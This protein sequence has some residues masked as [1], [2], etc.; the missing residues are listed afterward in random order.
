M[1]TS[2]A[3]LDTEKIMN[4]SNPQDLIGQQGSL[5]PTFLV[6]GFLGSGKTTFL[7]WLLS[8]SDASRVAVIVNEFGE[9]GLDH[10]L[11]ATPVENIMLIEG[12]CL[13]CEVRGDLVQTL[14]DLRKRRD[15]NEIRFFDKVV[16]E[17]TGLSNP[18]PIIQTLLCD[19]DVRDTYQLSK[20]ITTVDV[21]NAELQMEKHAE[22][23]RQTAIADLLLLTKIDLATPEMLDAVKRKIDLINPGA[24][25]IH[26][27]KASPQSVS[28]SDLLSGETAQSRQSF[29]DSITIA[30]S[31]LQNLYPASQPAS[32]WSR[33]SMTSTAHQVKSL[34]IESFVLRRPGEIDGPNLVIWLNL[35]STLKGERLL[36]LKAILNV[37]GRPIAIHAAQ[38]VVHEPVELSEW[39]SQDRDSRFVVI[40][41][42]SIRTE[43]EQSLALLDFQTPTPQDVPTFDPKAYQQFL[44][45]AEAMS[46]A[47]A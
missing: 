8:K 30:E 3:L 22:C 7:N 28:A 17:T 11:I 42:G 41:Q 24:G 27:V 15:N 14:T 2:C 12:G 16:I 34:G 31:L 37:E 38:T 20:I 6:T 40:S 21:V 18:V 32:L 19:E 10:L 39:P 46:K 23:I 13:C 44:R 43:F 25:Q 36:R 45:L 1:V 9:I 47:S 33:S 29:L 4:S 26:V 35:L 5:L